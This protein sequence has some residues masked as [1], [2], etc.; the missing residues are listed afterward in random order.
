MELQLGLALFPDIN[1]FEMNKESTSE[2]LKD[3]Y[4]S[5]N[6]KK[7]NFNEAFDHDES[8]LSTATETPQ[9][10]AL[11]SWDTDQTKNSDTEDVKPSH[12]LYVKVKME[13]APIARKVDLGQHHSY[14]SLATTLLHMFGKSEENMNDYK[15]VYQD[16]EG[17]WLLA[18][19]LPWKSFMM[20]V[21]CLK[22]IKSSHP[23]RDQ[24]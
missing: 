13:G 9:T 12:S 24:D 16:E 1:K 19:D 14:H 21:Q 5:G 18:E 7:R 22:W 6:P 2:P 8:C 3:V 15:L 11:F 10:L 20:S 17:D 4:G 23:D